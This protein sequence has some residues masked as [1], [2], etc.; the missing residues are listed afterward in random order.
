MLF[1]VEVYLGEFLPTRP[2]FWGFVPLEDLGPTIERERIHKC[3]NYKFQMGS[4]DT[5]I[6]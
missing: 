5:N 2:K 3:V 4:K 6:G 1:K